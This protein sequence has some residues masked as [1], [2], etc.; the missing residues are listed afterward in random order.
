MIHWKTYYNQNKHLPLPKII[1]A[2]NRLVN[3][4]LEY[5]LKQYQAGTPSAGSAADRRVLEY[6]PSQQPIDWYDN[7]G[8]RGYHTLNYFQTVDNDSV[9]VIVLAN[10]GSFPATEINNIDAYPNLTAI[11]FAGQLVPELNLNGILT[12][13]YL[14]LTSFTNLQNLDL[15]SN[16]NIVSL[17]VYYCGSLS[18]INLT[19][20]I[21]VNDIAIS[22]TALTSVDVRS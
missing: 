22:N 19:G 20:L 18:S 15:S 6:T 7:S 8:E 14:S 13:E 17:G 9:N 3:E 4:S 2:Y 5:G 10:P 12:L 21:N 11:Q 16:V 1:E